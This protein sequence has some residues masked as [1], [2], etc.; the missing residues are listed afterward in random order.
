MT[1]A[2]KVKVINKLSNNCNVESLHYN[3]VMRVKKMSDALVCSDTI[4][5]EVTF[6]IWRKDIILKKETPIRAKNTIIPTVPQNQPL[7]N[8]TNIKQTM[9]ENVKATNIDGNNLKDN[10]S[11][12]SSNVDIFDEPIDEIIDNNEISFVINS[13]PHL[14]DSLTPVQSNK[15]LSGP[16]TSLVQTKSIVL[17]TTTNLLYSNYLKAI[18]NFIIDCLKC[19]INMSFLKRNDFKNLSVHNDCLEKSLND[20]ITADLSEIIEVWSQKQANMAGLDGSLQTRTKILADHYMLLR[21]RYFLDE[22][23]TLYI[24]FT[25][26]GVKLFYL[27]V[28]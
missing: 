8:N 6:N 20:K 3:E 25:N 1:D 15:Q 24:F 4:N 17:D 2:S 16:P 27:F 12:I 13:N 26:F 5:C 28:G 23:E 7:E 11:D 18:S 14:L 19:I 21:F 22:T 9:P 10:I